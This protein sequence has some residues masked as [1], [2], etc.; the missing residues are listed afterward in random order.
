VS[1]SIK[2]SV[3]EIT[4]YSANWPPEIRS[5]VVPGELHGCAGGR[6]G[7]GQGMLAR[8]VAAAADPA[9]RDDVARGYRADRGGKGQAGERQPAAPDHLGERGGAADQCRP[10]SA[11]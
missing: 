2:C 4:Q 5:K 3:S 1:W 11:R 8:S 10:A 7:A 6:R 9:G